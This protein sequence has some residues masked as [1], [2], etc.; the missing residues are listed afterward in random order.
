MSPRSAPTSHVARSVVRGLLVASTL[1]CAALGAASCGGDDGDGIIAARRPKA[2]NGGQASAGRAGAAGSAGGAGNA[3]AAGATGG[4]GG[5]AGL[6]GA[7]AAGATAGSAG[8]AGAVVAGAA[9]AAGLAGTAGSAG[10][11]GAAGTSGGAAGAAGLGGAAG[12]TTGGSGP[13]E[14]ACVDGLDEDAD[15]QI[16]CADTDCKGKAVCLPVVPPEWTGPLTAVKKPAS[17]DAAPCANGSPSKRRFLTPG[18]AVHCSSCSCGDRSGASCKLGTV[19]VR[20]GASPDNACLGAQAVNPADASCGEFSSSSESGVGIRATL[21]E[22]KGSCP[23]SGGIVDNRPA[24]FEDAW[25][26]CPLPGSGLGCN[27]NLCVPITD[28]ASTCILQTGTDG[29]CPA[30]WPNRALVYDGGDDQRDCDP[31]TCGDPASVCSVGKLSLNK[32]P[33]C[34]PDISATKATVDV[35]GACRYLNSTSV[36]PEKWHFVLSNLDVVSTTCTVGGGTPKGKV[37]P[38]GGGVLCCL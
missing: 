36:L 8:S 2:G 22:V 29:V 27:G 3:G 32:T 20:S 9:G 16:D 38:K 14:Q 24:L 11:G 18:A 10:L 28:A 5:A 31:C 1:S 25:D 21:D 30:G 7:G 33:A 35:N 15:G 19:E 37:E 17:I 34:T 26:T 4:I 6:A 23:P 12:S 13:G